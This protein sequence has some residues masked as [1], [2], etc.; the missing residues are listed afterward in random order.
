MSKRGG[1]MVLSHSEHLTFPE[2]FLFKFLR[3][4][5]NHLYRESGIIC[6]GKVE[7]LVP[8]KWNYLYRESGIACT[9][10]VELFVPGKWNCLYRESGIACTKCQT[11]VV[12]FVYVNRRTKYSNSRLRRDVNDIFAFLG[13][14]TVFIVT[15]VSEK[16]V[17]F[18]LNP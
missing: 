12:R 15:D 6:T 7:L 3:F 4:Y 10:K 5:V 16:P 9:G 17:G 18:N 8:G 13:C 2:V 14:Y 1:V 11:I